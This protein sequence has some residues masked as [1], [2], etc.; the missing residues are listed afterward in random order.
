MAF[1]SYYSMPSSSSGYWRGDVGVAGPAPGGLREMGTATQGIGMQSAGTG[2]TV[3][4]T[5]WHP[6]VLYL[7]AL[8]VAECVIFGV[9]GRMLG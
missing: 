6:T 1:P 8:V 5:T 3:A 9:I 4:G 2:V 7:L